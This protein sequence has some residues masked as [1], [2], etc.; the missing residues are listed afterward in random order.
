MGDDR[1]ISD[2]LTPREAINRNDKRILGTVWKL[3]EEANVLITHNGA[4]FDMKKLN[5]RFWKNKF[6]RPS[7]YKMIDTLT[8]A[9]AAFGLTYNS[10]DFIAKY[11]NLQEKLD[12]DF[13]LWVACDHGDS[14][15]LKYM[16]E[17]NEQ[18]IRTQEEIYMNMRE[19]IPNHPDMSVFASMD[20]V[21]PVCLGGN[22]EQIGF[23]MAKKLMYPEHRCSDCGSIWHDSKAKE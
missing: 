19:W 6:H 15:A 17:Y 16:R 22:H 13:A 14:E 10:A 20:N 4:R 18:D 8:S 5:A 3:V 7:S 23:Y 2:I 9:K 11:L 21:C 12:T 1:I